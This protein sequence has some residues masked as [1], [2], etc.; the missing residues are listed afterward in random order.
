MIRKLKIDICVLFTIFRTLL[1]CR[2]DEIDLINLDFLEKIS[3]VCLKCFS[4]WFEHTKYF[5]DEL[6]V[7][8]SSNQV[9]YVK[10]SQSLCFSL[11]SGA[12][13]PR[14]NYNL[15]KKMFR[16]TLPSVW[17]LMAVIP[18]VFWIISSILFDIM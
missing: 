12:Q 18:Q 9:P 10:S 16:P 4:F 17:I 7:S 13:L 15:V 8:D 11:Q 1:K 2:L 6:V 3:I 14:E 5:N